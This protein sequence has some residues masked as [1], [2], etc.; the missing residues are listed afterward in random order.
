MNKEDKTK[1][2]TNMSFRCTK[3]VCQTIEKFAEQED[4]SI[5]NYLNRVVEKHIEDKNK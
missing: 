3:E 4:R 1:K 2:V 5:S